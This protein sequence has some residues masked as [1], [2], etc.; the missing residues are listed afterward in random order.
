MPIAYP[1]S[2][3]GNDEQRSRI[4]GISLRRFKNFAFFR[5]FLLWV[6]YGVASRQGGVLFP[7]R[8][9]FIELVDVRGEPIYAPVYTHCIV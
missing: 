4:V 2:T 6:E 8:S 1:P 5:Q 7:A 9:Q 3:I